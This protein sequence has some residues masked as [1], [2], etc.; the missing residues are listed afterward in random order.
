MVWIVPEVA[1]WVGAVLAI[2]MLMATLVAVGLV[3]VRSVVESARFLVTAL[4]APMALPPVDST[5]ELL[6]LILLTVTIFISQGIG[7]TFSEARAADGLV[8]FLAYC[9]VVSLSGLV[10]CLAIVAP[11]APVVRDE[12]GWSSCD[13]YVESN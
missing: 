10:V 2:L 8:R 9:A 3:T 5:F 11:R 7:V 13:A 12:E 4:R 6:P 1:L